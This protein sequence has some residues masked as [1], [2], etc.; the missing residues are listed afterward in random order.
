MTTQCCVKMPRPMIEVMVPRAKAMM[1]V[2]MVVKTLLLLMLMLMC[3]A[4]RCDWVVI[5][6]VVIRIWL[7]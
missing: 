1:L 2:T 3:E 6:G 7:T 4:M 5:F